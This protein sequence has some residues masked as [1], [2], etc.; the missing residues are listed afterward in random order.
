MG[1]DAIDL[2]CSLEKRLGIT[3]PVQEGVAVFF[4]TPQTLH[5]YLVAKVEGT[6]REVADINK[7][8]TEVLK[9]VRRV[10]GWWTFRTSNNLNWRFPR[11]KRAACW[12]ALANELGVSLPPLDHPPGEKFPRIP[13]HC[14]SVIALTYWIIQNHPDRVKWLP[15]QS[16][17]SGLTAA[18]TWTENDIWEAMCDCMVDSLGVKREKITPHARMVEDL[19]LD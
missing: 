18:R 1:L 4:D 11:R 10:T 14:G 5:R 12:Q 17:P 9:A 3:I 13:R 6:C 8:A 15:A 16:E 2:C 7:T 19:G